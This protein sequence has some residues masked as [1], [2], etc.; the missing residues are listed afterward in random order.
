M[1]NAASV[2]LKRSWKRD[3]TAASS[4]LVALRDATVNVAAGEGP[5]AERFDS[6]W[7]ESLREV[8]YLRALKDPEE[9]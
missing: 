5:F 2:H 4:R 7:D 9:T 3:P 6:D 1:T 8:G